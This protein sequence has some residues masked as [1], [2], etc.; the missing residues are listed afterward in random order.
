MYEV[1]TRNDEGMRDEKKKMRKRGKQR[2][3]MA[4]KKR[5]KEKRKRCLENIYI[6]PLR[7]GK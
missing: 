5:R 1:A 3:N 7:G 6:E 4:G 2:R